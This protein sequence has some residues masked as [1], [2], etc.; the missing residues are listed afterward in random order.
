MSLPQT[1]RTSRLVGRRAT[2]QDLAGWRQIFTDAAVTATLTVDG[3]P[4]DDQG[5]QARLGDAVAS[6]ERPGNGSWAFR[7]RD[8]GD[9]VG[10]VYL[11][12]APSVGPGDVE[13]GW[14]VV[15]A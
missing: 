11:G 3:R 5:V 15:R 7:R 9:F 8:T 1:L 4:L 2:A 6:W 12:P 13:I 14:A 10:R